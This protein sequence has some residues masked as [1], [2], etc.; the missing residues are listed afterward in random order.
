MN[1][2]KWMLIVL[3]FPAA[4]AAAIHALLYKR[5]PRAA[6]GWIG[7]CLFV[8]IAGPLFY[9]LFGINRIRTRA[10]KLEQKA[11]FRIR[12]GYERAADKDWTRFNSWVI[13]TL[14]QES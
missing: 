8:P 13:L 12:I 4:L 1:I 9:F 14:S 10:H 11:P 6:L 7:V 5:D 2:F 3:Y